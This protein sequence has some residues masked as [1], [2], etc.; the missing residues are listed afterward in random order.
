MFKIKAFE[1]G[2]IFA[3][4]FLLPAV[5]SAPAKSMDTI[6]A[7]LKNPCG[8]REKIRHSRSAKERL[9][10]SQLNITKYEYKAFVQSLKK[11]YDVV[12]ILFEN[13]AFMFY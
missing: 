3:T 2:L 7:K 8:Y 13:K 5:L 9:L 4:F 12:S 1:V 10:E 6:D 11:L